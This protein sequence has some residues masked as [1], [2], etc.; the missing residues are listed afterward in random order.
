LQIKT[1]IVAKLLPFYNYLLSF[2]R[3]FNGINI[4]M[5]KW[6]YITVVFVL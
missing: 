2:Q 3:K 6:Q 1:K 5:V 4:A